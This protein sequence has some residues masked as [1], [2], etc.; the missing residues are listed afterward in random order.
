MNPVWIPNT[1]CDANAGQVLFLPSLAAAQVPAWVNMV[2]GVSMSPHHPHA[3]SNTM[4]WV[5]SEPIPSSARYGTAPAG[6]KKTR[7]Q[8]TPTKRPVKKHPV[9]KRPVTEYPGYPYTKR[10]FTKRPVTERSGYKTF[11]TKNVFCKFYILLKKPFLSEIPSLHFYLK[12]SESQFWLFL[13]RNNNIKIMRR[14]ICTGQVRLVHTW[15][16]FT[17]QQI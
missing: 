14:L 3:A 9:T 1:A 13:P 8:D 16:L 17:Q 15:R 12:S 5:R 4:S 10:P 7:I 2:E 6:L 11:G